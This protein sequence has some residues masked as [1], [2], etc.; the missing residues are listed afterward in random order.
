VTTRNL[1]ILSVH[2]GYLSTSNKDRV[3]EQKVVPSPFRTNLNPSATSRNNGLKEHLNHKIHSPFKHVIMKV[4]MLLIAGVSLLLSSCST[5]EKPLQSSEK[6]LA[7]FLAIDSLLNTYNEKEAFMGSVA[8]RQ[9]EKTVYARAIGYSD[10][11]L[12]KK[13]TT[14][15]K[16]RLGST[17]KVFTS[18]L[19]FMAIE[20][21]KIQLKQTVEAF[22]PELVNARE[23]TIASLLHHRSGIPNF[24]SQEEF[25]EYRTIYRSKDDMLSMISNFRSEFEPDSDANYSNSNYFLLALILEK[26]YETSY[27]GLLEAKIIR[28]LGLE[29]TFSG[30]QTDLKVND[31]YSYSY[32]DN[33]IEFPETDI[34]VTL[35]GAS[36]SSTPMDVNRFMS[37]LFAGK[38]ISIESLVQMKT[39]R[40]DFG[41][42]IF[43]YRIHDRQGFGHRG[44]L[45]EF[46]STAVYFPEEQLG[47]TITTN[48]SR[49]DVS[50]VYSEIL[51]LYF[52]DAT[53]GISEI[54]LSKFVGTFVSR[55]DT[56][57]R[58]V[59]IKTQN[60]L[61]HVIKNEFEVPLVYKGGNRF[62]FNQLYGESISFTFSDDGREL[63]FVQGD[64]KGIYLKQ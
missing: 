59:F 10:I 1:E 15:T 17:S 38:L 49:I 25:K 36:I 29:N 55:R 6:N 16:Y 23:I 19:V 40:D 12:R 58:V 9:N 28:P 2:F 7:K 61:V 5:P 42:G 57:D 27:E 48:A 3:S 21:N 54:E 47:F 8:F 13:S 51:K 50:K 4:Q 33:W 18:T 44:R 22:F 43:R 53:I 63:T 56:S 64:F 20:E 34:S 45:D 11:E 30:K 31:S 35:G 24:T 60:V 14:H 39:I 37:A 41:M 26:I 62:I 52:D 46:R 32:K